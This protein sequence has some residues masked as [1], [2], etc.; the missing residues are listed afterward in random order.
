[1]RLI[2]LFHLVRV[3]AK[4]STEMAIILLRHLTFWRFEGLTYMQP[5]T[6][7]DSKSMHCYRKSVLNIHRS[8]VIE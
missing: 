2:V 7:F 8:I 3:L 6:F 4:Y 5:A 1:M